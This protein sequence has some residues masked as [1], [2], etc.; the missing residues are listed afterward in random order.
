[1]GAQQFATGS[2]PQ[3][4]AQPQPHEALARE[5]IQPP[6]TSELNPPN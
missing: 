6:V 3:M 2:L 4:A 1:L 5:Q